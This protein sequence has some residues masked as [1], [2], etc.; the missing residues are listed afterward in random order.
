MRPSAQMACQVHG[1]VPTAR[2]RQ[3]VR[4]D[5][6]RAGWRPNGDRFERLAPGGSANHGPGKDRE[7]ARHAHIRTAVDHRRHVHARLRQVMRGLV[8]IVVVS[9]DCNPAARAHAPAVEIRAYCAR[10]HHARAVV[11]PERDPALDGT[12]RQDRGLRGDPPERLQRRTIPADL[13][14]MSDPLQRA[15]DALVI[16]PGHRRPRHPPH[17]RQAVEFGQNPIDPDMAG[18]SAHI[19]TLGQQTPA[20]PRILVREDHV[21]ACATRRQ[22]CHQ[23]RRARADHQQ[24]AE[25]IALVVLVLVGLARQRPEPG[26]TPDERLVHLLPEHPGPHEGL[27]V[28]ARPQEWRGQIVDAQQVEVEAGP[29][30]LAGGLQ[31]AVKLLYRRAHIRLRARAMTDRHQRIGLLRPGRPDA[32]RPVVLERTPHQP[33]LVRQQGRGQRVAGQALQP[34]PVESEGYRSAAVDEP[35]SGNPHAPAPFTSPA[36]RTRVDLVRRQVAPHDEPRATSGLVL[37]EIL[38]PAGRVLAQMHVVRPK[39]PHPH[40]DPADPARTAAP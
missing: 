21:R 2:D 9:E 30:V 5:L 22:R 13:A 27:V 20:H 40:P 8:G 33:D 12:R 16:G 3:A 14:M 6:F 35:P 24:V 38:M 29:A 25:E 34:L 17:V 28:E 4:R 18:R 11:V 31:P 10:L 26:R 32:A 15:I 23:T 37:P 36:R 1:R 39:P 7:R 19:V